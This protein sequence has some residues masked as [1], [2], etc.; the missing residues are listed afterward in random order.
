MDTILLGFSFY[1]DTDAVW[2]IILFYNMS[3]SQ[4]IK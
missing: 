4:Y 3:T 2:V 1:L